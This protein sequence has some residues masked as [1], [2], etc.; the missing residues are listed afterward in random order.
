MGELRFGK[1]SKCVKESDF[2]SEVG[3]EAIASLHCQ[4]ELVVE[5]LDNA[6]GERFLGFEI[7]QEQMAMGLESAGDFLEGFEATFGDAGAPGVEELS[8]SS[9]RRVGPEMLKAFYQQ[10]GAQ[11]AQSAAHQI[12]HA[13]PVVGVPVAAVFEERPTRLLKQWSQSGAGQRMD[14]RAADLVDGFAEVLADMKAVEDMQGGWQGLGDDAQIGLPEVRANEAHLLAAPGSQPMKNRFQAV[15]GA[16]LAD[17]EQAACSLIDLIDQR[18]ELAFAHRDFID[19]QSAKAVQVA[20]P[21]SPAHH[22]FD[23]S[24][25]IGP[26]NAKTR[27]HFLPGKQARPL[28]QEKAQRVAELQFA[29]GPR[30]VFDMHSAAWALHAPRPVNQEHGNRP[31]RNK[32]PAPRL[33]A[34]VVNRRRLLAAPAP[35]LRPLTGLNPDLDHPLAKLLPARPAIA[36]SLEGQHPSQYAC[37]CYVHETGWLMQSGWVAQPVST[38]SPAT[39]S[40]LAKVPPERL[41]RRAVRGLGA[42]SHH[43]TGPFLPTH[44]FDEP[45]FLWRNG[46][47]ELVTPISSG[48]GSRR[49]IGQKN[50]SG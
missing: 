10:E 31:H 11:A 6:V 46:K 50:Q 13:A 9:A 8:G 42:H 25:H 22:P 23:R 33:V 1:F 2:T 34:C 14:L 27:S 5:S 4:F 30:Q 35:R 7:V 29:A 17:P 39:R 47:I 43:Q 28:G 44:S 45:A 41:P 40:A 12:T 32:A 24:I 21:Q 37:Q 19:S 48:F 18:P 36:E 38:F 20:V 16:V 3:S 15:A 49:I 26:R